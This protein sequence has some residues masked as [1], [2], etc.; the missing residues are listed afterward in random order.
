[1]DNQLIERLFERP[2]A[3]HRIFVDLTGSVQAALMLSQAFYWSKRTTLPDGWFYKP[4]AEWTEET[5]LTRHEQDTARK[6]LKKTTFWKEKLAGVPAKCH[7]KV[8]KLA[9]F[10]SLLEI[11]KQESQFAENRQTS[12]PESG[13]HSI[14]EITTETTISSPNGDDSKKPVFDTESSG[15]LSLDGRTSEPPSKKVVPVE[16]S[17]KEKKVPRENDVLRKSFIATWERLFPTIPLKFPRDGKMVNELID[18]CRVIMAKMGVPV[19]DEKVS[20]FFDIAMQNL[21]DWYRGKTMPIINS[22][23][24]TIIDQ[25]ANGK[26]K[27][28]LKN[29]ADQ[30]SRFA[31]FA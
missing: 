22:H 16:K 13:K 26:A 19:D 28:T 27:P 15:Q 25:I 2:V 8:D 14:T 11:G 3:F 1:M 7:F 24:P 30:F 18:Q 4:T 23:F 12:S 5:G 21:P 17:Q 29:S 10:S 9:L 20:E 6:F 31:G